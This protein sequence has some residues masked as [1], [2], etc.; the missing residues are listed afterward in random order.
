M[1]NQSGYLPVSVVRSKANAAVANAQSFYISDISS[2]T[3]WGDSLKGVAVIVHAAA[4][5]HVMKEV[6][7]D[8]LTEF[9]KINV[10]GTVN[11]ARQ[12]AQAGVKRF[13]F[14]SS[15]KVNGEETNP[16]H[17]FT[18][19]DNPAPSDPYGISKKEA[20]GA[21]LALSQ[22]TG[23]EVVIIRPTLIYGPGV[24]ANFRNMM[25]WLKKGIPLPFG[26]IHNKRSLVSLENLVSLI[27]VCLKH[28]NAAGQIFL[29][30]DGVDLSTTELLN[31][32]AEALGVKSR[33]I[34]VP[35]RLLV[36]CAVALGRRALS[37]RLCGSL[38]VDISKTRTLL[39][40]NPPVSV[41]D[42]LNRTAKEFLE[43]R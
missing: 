41:Q 4:R 36:F 8:A 40:W 3:E 42:A 2:S 5:V 29:V 13:V 38:Q 16:G 25:G 10:E 14:I 26:A 28:D 30:S 1:D 7:A 24:K 23:M 18:A 11:L 35:E 6:A 34:P 21:L 43:Y 19:D 37:Q 32:T 17:P 39:G 20:E 12:A 27:L 15:I 9:R 31:R 33:L 22:E